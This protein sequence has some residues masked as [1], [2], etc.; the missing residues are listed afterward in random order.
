MQQHPLRID[1]ASYL[2]TFAP[3][4][5]SFERSVSVHRQ[6]G[7]LCYHKKVPG[8]YG[9]SA[10]AC[11]RGRGL[12]QQQCSR[13]LLGISRAGELMPSNPLISLNM[14]SADRE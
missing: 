10:L 7:I 14:T 12:E 13:S 2:Q 11:S 5:P 3:N 1:D 4:S 9:I 6:T 8:V